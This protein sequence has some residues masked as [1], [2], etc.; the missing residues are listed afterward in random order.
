MLMAGNWGDILKLGYLRK[1]QPKVWY[2]RKSQQK[3]W[4]LAV[5][6][7]LPAVLVSSLWADKF[8]FAT[9]FDRIGVVFLIAA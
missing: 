8:C 7:S 6:T 2:L 1:S 3:V 4:S 5:G 9:Y